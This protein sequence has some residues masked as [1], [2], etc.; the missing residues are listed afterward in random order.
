MNVLNY[1]AAAGLTALIL[2]LMVV[3]NAILLPLVIA[4]FVCY[5]INALAAVTRDIRILGWR[6]PNSLR[7]T[8]AIVVFLLG[9]WFVLT[10][11]VRNINQV[12]A[13]VP[14]YQKNLQLAAD[15]ISTRF[16][17]QYSVRLQALFTNID[18]GGMANS[19][20][21]AVAVLIGS[22][23]T[24]AVYVVF[25]LLEQHSLDKKIAA[26]FP[27][28]AREAMVHRILQRIGTQIQTYVW[29]KTL[30]SV[31]VGIGSYLVMKIVGVDFA[32]FW[33][34]LIFA[35]NYIP[36]LGALSGVIFPSLLALVQFPT[37]SPSLVTAGLL[38]VLQFTCGSIIEPK[39]MGKGLNLSPVVM[40]LALSVWGT[41]WG[42]VGM[43]LAV[44]LMVVVM[45]VCSHF[46]STRGIAVLMSAD[47]ELRNYVDLKPK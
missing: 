12:T 17:A 34:L 37:L 24:V 1:A 15:R 21:R 45:I 32:E 6:L 28:P 44:P 2:Y 4:V 25:L 5:L 35:L 11:V 22:I 46:E 47:G 3:G 8:A 7:L 39:L 9:S 43:F 19:L 26:L 27:G 23:G 14:V 13:A 36:Y 10:L 29:L 41:I 20:A 40:L 30:M 18:L 38:T 42:I 31:V 33:A 16:G